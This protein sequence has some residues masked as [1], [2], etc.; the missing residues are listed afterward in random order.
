MDLRII[1]LEGYPSGLCILIN[2]WPSVNL[3]E[4]PNLYRQFVIKGTE[5]AK[6]LGLHAIWDQVNIS[7]VENGS[8][9]S[10]RARF[11]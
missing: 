6:A 8:R 1:A 5:S 7:M 11:S 3:P 2:I 4:H 10:E 9:G